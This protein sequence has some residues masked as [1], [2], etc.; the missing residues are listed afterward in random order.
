MMHTW[1]K[2]CGHFMSAGFAR[3]SPAAVAV[4][5]AYRFCS[6][7]GSLATKHGSMPAASRNCQGEQPALSHA[8]AASGQLHL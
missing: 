1:P 8:S 7:V 2:H 4:Y 3:P 6:R 5:D